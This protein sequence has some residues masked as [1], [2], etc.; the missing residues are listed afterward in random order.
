MQPIMLPDPE[1]SGGK[2]VLAALQERK[3]NRRISPKP[4]PPQMLSNLLWAAYGFN[5]TDAGLRGKPGR[6]AASWP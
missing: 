1:K 2:S 4:L 3:T 6:T 5:R